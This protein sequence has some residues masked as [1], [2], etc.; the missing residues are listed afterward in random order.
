[1]FIVQGSVMEK[2][3]INFVTVLLAVLAALFVFQ[4]LQPGPKPDV[5]AVVALSPPLQAIHDDATQAMNT[6]RIAVPEF[7]MNTGK[8]P[9]SNA[10]AGLPEPEAFRGKSLER[11]DVDGATVTLTFDSTS[12]IYGGT[13][14]FTGAATP[15]MAMGITW[16]CESP[17]YRDIAAA[18]ADCVYS[19]H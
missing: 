4:R 12:G 3:I 11:L 10:S 15:Q 17:S 1:V 8:W 18:I 14:V 7:Y 2:W 9:E 19:G 13:V 5:N 16:K 6:V